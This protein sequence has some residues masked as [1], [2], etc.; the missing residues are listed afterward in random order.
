MGLRIDPID[1]NEHRQPSWCYQNP[2][3]CQAKP[4]DQNRI[5]QAIQGA[6]RWTYTDGRRNHRSEGEKAE[7]KYSVHQDR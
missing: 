6:S 3:T 2:E 7:I 5:T 4:A 1:L